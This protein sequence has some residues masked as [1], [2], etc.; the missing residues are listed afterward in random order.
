MRMTPMFFLMHLGGSYSLCIVNER[1][2]K[3]NDQLFAIKLTLNT[4][5][6]NYLLFNLNLTEKHSLELKFT[7]HF[8]PM[9][10][11]LDSL[12]CKLINNQ[13]YRLIIAFR[14]LSKR[15]VSSTLRKLASAQTNNAAL[16]P[17]DCMMAIENTLVSPIYRHDFVKVCSSA[18]L[19]LRSLRKSPLTREIFS[20]AVT[21]S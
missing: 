5:I 11:K 20:S 7:M 9:L 15:L 3:I 12:V 16:C 2:G 6:I 17:H 4:N 8:S 14:G 19:F 1:L 18:A 10:N 21:E 13:P